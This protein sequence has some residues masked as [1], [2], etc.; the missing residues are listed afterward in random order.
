M[1][2]LSI[3]ASIIAVLQAGDRFTSLLAQ[4]KPFFEA[5][6]EVE[7]LSNEVNELQL[8]LGDLREALPDLPASGTLPVNKI[9]VLHGLIREGE[10][11]LLQLEALIQQ[12]FIKAPDPNGMGT[13]KV[14]RLAWVKKRGRVEK[15]RR[16]LRDL[17][18]T[19]AVQL[20]SVNL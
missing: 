5:Q 19:I 9:D 11:T 20:A 2:P 15:L 14:R 1:D 7:S 18:L 4:I 6:E 16:R 12:R 17:R 10:A 13:R 3:T 8:V